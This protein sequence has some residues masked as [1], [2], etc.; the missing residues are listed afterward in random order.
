MYI[1]CCK[2]KDAE[3]ERGGGDMN[4]MLGADAKS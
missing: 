3:K 4:E 1:F 2:V